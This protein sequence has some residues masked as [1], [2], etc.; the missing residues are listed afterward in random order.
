MQIQRSVHTVDTHTEGQP[1]RILT[2]GLGFLPGSSIAARREYFQR[3]MDH[4]RTALMAEPRGHRDMYGCILTQPCHPDAE[5]GIIYAHNSGYMDMCGHATIGL[6]TALVELG[7]VA[8]QEP[9]TRIVY[10]SVGGLV[11]ACVKVEGGK[12][13][14]VTFENVPGRVHYLDATLKVEGLG[15]L[16]VDVAYGGN[17]FVWFD[18]DAIGLPIH[19]QNARQIVDVG[20]RVMAAA[21]EQLPI[22][23]PTTGQARQ[24][25]IA[26]ALTR[27]KT[28]GGPAVRNVHVFGPGQFD[29]SPGGTGT[30]ARLSVLRAKGQLEVGAPVVVESGISDGRFTGHLLGEVDLGGGVTGYRTT[31]TGSAFLT[32]MHQFVMDPGDRLKDGFLVQ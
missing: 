23:D 19:D 21:N 12:A 10:D 25:N 3:H 15:A 18:A 5:V 13:L 22:Q 9:E 16:Q 30:T 11:T 1:T 4:L 29:R 28:S 24:V 7:M 32:G 6:S 17:D 27:P 14:E 31:V 20:M 26:T 8:V 2:G